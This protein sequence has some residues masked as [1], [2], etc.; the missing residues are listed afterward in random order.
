MT[1]AARSGQHR[2]PAGV[3]LLAFGGAVVVLLGL[4]GTAVNQVA[5]G[6]AV[7]ESPAA[8]PLTGPA[9]LAHLAAPAGTPGPGG[10][11]DRSTLVLYDRDG[12][13]PKLGHQYAIQAA[14]LASRGG[15]WAMR[16]VERYR[17]GDI[18]RHQAVIY[19]GIA[20]RPLPSAFLADVA[21]GG[22]PVLW[23]GAGVEQLFE[24]DG[25]LA[26]R[27]GWSPAGYDDLAVTGVEY[28]GRL[29]KRQA[30][31]NDAPIRIGVADRGP[32]QV[33]GLA[34][35]R[36]GSSYPWAVTSGHLTY[37]GEIPF[38]YAE[39]RDRYLAAADIILRMVAPE[40]PE[41]R[42]ALIRIED[43]GPHTKPGE[44]IAIADYLS[45][46]G[47]PFTLAVFPYYRDPH[48]ASNSGRPTAYRLVDRPE[49]VN[50]LRY[51][52]RRGGTIIM[53]GYS[54]QFEDRNNPYTGASGGDY[55]F[56]LAHVDADNNVRLDG[57]VPPDS[58]S[59]A[60]R[61]LSV[62]RAEFVRVGLDDPAIFEFPHYTASA[63]SY[64]AV[65]DM[66]AVRYDQG[67]YFDGL[68]PEGDCSDESR[69]TGE[70]FQQFF[71][72]P[73]RD[74]YGSVV[75]PE[76]LLNISEAYNNNPA[77]TARDIVAAAAAM[78]VVRD[79]VASTFYHPFLG[80]ER[81]AEVVEG[82]TALGYEFVSPYQLLA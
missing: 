46:R 82:I 8:A 67:T 29:L 70:L 2:W 64:R 37:I 42:R 20:D 34:R 50:A 75:I 18:A 23:M 40:A 74:V 53:H 25:S 79:S 48:G 7:T 33:L 77:R 69:P 16:P 32:A 78:T 76:N 38:T 39:P 15:A 80:V 43:V 41:R 66:F 60:A 35:H 51:A 44:I 21:R 5:G 58:E 13:E 1:T 68:C 57:P 27:A 54:H 31:G 36:D 61:R 12:A 81:L 22:V 59:W 52:T 4:T 30:A 11:P 73:V 55:E 72:Y 63:A 45:G 9:R 65:H 6:S 24:F 49:L 71:P 28:R 14:N 3:R 26:T 17:S 19:I 56:F 62:G 10:R 47:V